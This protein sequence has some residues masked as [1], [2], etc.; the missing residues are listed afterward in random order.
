MAF[1]DFYHYER[2][3]VKLKPGVYDVQLTRIY[4]TNINGYRV[5]KFEFKVDG[6]TSLTAPG[7]FILFDCSDHTDPEKVNM[8]IRRASKIKECFILKGGFN[9]ANY[10]AWTNKKGQ[11]VVSQD[12]AGFLNVG[13]F[14]P[15][16]KLTDADRSM[17]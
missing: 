14:L 13:D 16:E 5:L 10:V 11:I 12:S 9:E 7:N 6:I 1:G 3:A 2:Q 4:E 17:L 8:F 15:N